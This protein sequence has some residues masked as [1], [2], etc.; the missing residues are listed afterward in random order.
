[1]DLWERKAQAARDLGRLLEAIP[2]EQ[3]GL[4]YGPLHRV[5]RHVQLG[6]QALALLRAAI[7]CVDASMML[8]ENWEGDSRRVL[9]AAGY[10]LED[11]GGA[12]IPT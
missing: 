2:A 7:G 11:N 10:N 1:M 9:E 3:R 8:P 5:E 12:D 4:I 6:L